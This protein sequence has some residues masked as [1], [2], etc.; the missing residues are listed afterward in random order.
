MAVT[1]KC[2]HQIRSAIKSGKST[3]EIAKSVGVQPKTVAAFRS[4]KPSARTKIRKG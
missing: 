3:G 4:G 1:R 2:A